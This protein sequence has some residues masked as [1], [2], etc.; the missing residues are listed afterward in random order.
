MS[1]WE[2]WISAD[3]LPLLAKAAMGH[4]WFETLHP[5]SDGDG[6]PGRLVVVLQLIYTGAL[7]YPTLDISP[8]LEARKDEY[9]DQLLRLSESGEPGPW[10]EFFCGAVHHQ[11]DDAVARIEKI[12]QIREWMR[13]ALK[14]AKARGVVLDLVDDLIAYPMI[15]ASLAARLH[16]VTYPPSNAAIQKLVELGFLTETTGRN[17][18][19][20]FAC[21]EIMAAVE[22][23]L[24]T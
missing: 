22:G 24:R 19:R 5:F 12:V 10:L 20:I 21:R 7:R 23:P 17:D 1:D 15:T 3:D 2:K 4:Y 6:R 13:A 9:Q 18:G 11:A 8:W 16:S 14:R